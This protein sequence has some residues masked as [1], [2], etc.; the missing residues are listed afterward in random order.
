MLLGLLLPDPCDEHCPKEFK[1]KARELLP[2]VQGQVASK[3]EYLLKSLHKFIGYFA[4]WDLSSTA[5]TWK[6]RRGSSKQRIPKKHRSSLIHLAA[7]VRYRWKRY[8]LAAKHSRVIST[9]SR[10]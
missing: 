4:N 8:G 3:D 6:F 2:K 1:Q 10:A 5:L 7:A 9:L